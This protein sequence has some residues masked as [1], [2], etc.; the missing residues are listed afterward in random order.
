VGGW[1][2]DIDESSN[3]YM[4]T[5]QNMAETPLQ[6]RNN[7]M[8]TTVGPF[9]TGQLE[10][11]L[12]T[13][14]LLLSSPIVSNPVAERS[15]ADHAIRTSGFE[16]GLTENASFHKPHQCSGS[17]ISAC[18]HFPSYPYRCSAE[19]SWLLSPSRL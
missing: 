14:S 13:I 11:G 3:D 17:S 1:R 9:R 15:L 2:Q 12:F 18:S 19:E 5:H 4:L 10:G 6:S 8:V 7:G 16:N